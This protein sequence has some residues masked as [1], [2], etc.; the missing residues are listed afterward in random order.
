MN[1]DSCH[2]L[3]GAALSRDG[4][5]SSQASL[6]SVMPSHGHVFEGKAHVQVFCY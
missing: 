4:D 3:A 5:E 2:P 1:L 6:V